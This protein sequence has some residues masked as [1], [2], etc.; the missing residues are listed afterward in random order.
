MGPNQ[1]DESISAMSGSTPGVCYPTIEGSAAA[2]AAAS[3]ASPTSVRGSDAIL[4]P[5]DG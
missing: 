5:P 2:R 1:A 3:P 4:L